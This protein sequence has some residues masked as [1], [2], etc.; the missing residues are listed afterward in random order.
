M[1]FADSLNIGGNSIVIGKYC[2]FA[3]DVKYCGANHPM[4]MISM[5][6]LFYNENLFGFDVGLEKKQL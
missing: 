1:G 2:S 4:N 5:H 3:N 6:P